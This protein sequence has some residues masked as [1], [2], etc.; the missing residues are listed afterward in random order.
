MLFC[1]SCFDWRRR[2]QFYVVSL[3]IIDAVEKEN[4]RGQKQPRYPVCLPSVWVLG[5]FRELPR[6][7]AAGLVPGAQGEVTHFTFF[8]PWI[9]CL[10]FGLPGLGEEGWGSV[11]LLVSPFLF[12]FFIPH[13]E[14][15]AL[16][17][18]FFFM[19]SCSS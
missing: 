4:T 10:C 9:G 2:F 13:P 5:A 19:V 3:Y 16:L 15:L 1:V 7:V 12:L 17:K 8:L 11:N 18:V 14:T 6:A